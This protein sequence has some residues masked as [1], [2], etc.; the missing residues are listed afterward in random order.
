MK[1]D[2]ISMCSFT[3]CVSNM[4]VESSLRWLSAS[5]MTKM[6]HFDS[7]SLTVVY[8]RSGQL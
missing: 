3:M 4:E 1:M 8:I 2:S 5:T 6:H 7:I